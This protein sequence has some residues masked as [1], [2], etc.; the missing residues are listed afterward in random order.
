MSADTLN[1]V[2]A[3]AAGNMGRNVCR[4]VS[5]AE[6]MRVA[7]AVDPNL[8]GGGPIP[9]E[10]RESLDSGAGS[11][12]SISEALS[13][14]QADVLVDFTWAEAAR[15]N[16]LAAVE[17]GVAAVV[18]TTGLGRDD[19]ER[20]EAAAQAAGTAVLL[21]PNFA[22][23]AVLMM[24]FAR[25]S[26]RHLDRCEIVE[27]HH[28]QKRDAPS[29]TARR[30]ADLIEEVWTSAGGNRS[31]P[32]HSVRLQGVVADQE[33]IFGALGQTLTISHRTTSRESFMP[34]VILA[35]RRVRDLQG[36]VVGLE[37]IL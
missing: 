2:V 24:E 13:V 19:L 36:L 22:L 27:L 25:Q 16:V 29:G 11:F 30:T 31:V 3:G 6:G 28:E 9:E 37:N 33:V 32:I 4:A 14:V 23:G 20:M 34:G 21:A 12:I 35:V 10:V 7:A 26:A 8:G 1:V 15:S 5:E 17:R 18:G